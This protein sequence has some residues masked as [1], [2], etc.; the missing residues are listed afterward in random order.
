MTVAQNKRCEDKTRKIFLLGMVFKD[1]FTAKIGVFSFILQEFP[2][3]VTNGKKDIQ[4]KAYN[5]C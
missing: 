1:F 5:L 2:E 4:S 3:I